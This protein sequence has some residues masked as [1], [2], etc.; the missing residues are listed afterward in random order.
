MWIIISLCAV[1]IVVAS[2]WERFRSDNVI[3]EWMLQTP[4]LEGLC[5]DYLDYVDQMSNGQHARSTIH[6]FDS[7]R[8]VT[9]DQILERLGLD[10]SMPIDM[11]EFCQRYLGRR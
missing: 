6:Y 5:R 3:K 8:Q 4:Y 1:L 7:Q 9:H 11:I 10:R 2:L